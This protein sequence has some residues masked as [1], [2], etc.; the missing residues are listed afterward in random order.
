MT[1]QTLITS[2]TRDGITFDVR[3]LA[4]ATIGPMPRRP[5]P[6][7]ETETVRALDAAVRE[8]DA[9]EEALRDK[10]AQLRAAI[11]A[12]AREATDPDSDLTVTAIAERVGW[13]RETISRIASAAGI[14]QTKGPKKSSTTRTAG[15]RNRVKTE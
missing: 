9:A 6:I 5:A 10:D 3:D 7:T 2:A 13:T 11:V 4:H 1:Y 15:A 8:Y 12:A 14:K